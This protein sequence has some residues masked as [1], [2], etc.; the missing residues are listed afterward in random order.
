MPKNMFKTKL[1]SGKFTTIMELVPNHLELLSQ[2][3]KLKPIKV[4][5][6]SVVDS[7]LSHP[8]MNPVALCYEVHNLL[9]KEAIMHFTCRDRNL[10]GIEEDI[11]AAYA[12][13]IKNILALTGDPAVGAKPVFEFSSKGLIEFIEK[14]NKEKSIDCFVGAGMEINANSLENEIK[15][16][17]IKIKKGAKFIITQPCFDIDRIKKSA[18]S[19]DASLIIGVIPIF[20]KKTAKFLNKKV[21]GIVIPDEV[22]ELMD[23]KI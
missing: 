14:L 19:L 15:R 3:K 21:K 4:D 7:P 13:D 6:F 5:F 20:S 22:I 11:L 9:K 8:L 23:D 1:D 12:L 10:V 17:K 2:V 16:T 18:Q